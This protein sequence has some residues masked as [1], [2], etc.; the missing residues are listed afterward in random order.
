[1]RILLSANHH[2][3]AFETEGAGFLPIKYP[4]GSGNHIHDLLARG[5]AESGHEVFYLLRGGWLAPLPC[6]VVPIVEPVLDVDLY[7]SVLIPGINED[8]LR[9]IS[10]Q[11]RAWVATCHLDQSRAGPSSLRNWIFVSRH[12]AKTH[13][14]DRYVWN[15]IDP[16]Q[17]VFSEAKQEYLLFIASMEHA[18]E[19]GLHT[20]LQ[21]SHRRGFHLVVAGSARTAETIAAVRRLCQSYGAEYVG[22]VRG[23]RKA[24]LIASAKALLFPSRMNEGCP[25]VILEA[26]ASGTPVISSAV[27]GCA[28]ILTPRTGF[29]C[30]CL[31]DFCA[32]VDQLHRIRPSDCRRD[33]V[34]RFH[35]RR[36]T[37]DYIREYER[38][39]AATA[40]DFR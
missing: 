20:A 8:V 1:M 22:D 34:E 39:I 10:E 35:Y 28:E 38:E 26:L 21:L 4:S 36:M 13:G 14:S 31:E 19:K 2:Y 25:V 15:G 30:D 3:P 37:A 40:G 18:Q 5:L 23:A 16:D 29:L 32:A 9:M 27:G 7:H 6:G 17:Y 11:R 24:D 33:A 12:L